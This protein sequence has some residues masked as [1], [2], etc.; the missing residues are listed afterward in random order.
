[1][2]LT[3]QK[4]ISENMEREVRRDEMGDFERQFSD[5][6][7]PD[8]LREGLKIEE[9]MEKAELTKKK[10]SEIPMS[11]HPFIMSAHAKGA[12]GVAARPWETDDNH[13]MFGNQ[14]GDGF[15]MVQRSGKSYSF[16]RLW[17]QEN[18]P[19][20]EPIKENGS[21]KDVVATLADHE[22][23]EK[24]TSKTEIMERTREKA[25]KRLA[26]PWEEEQDRIK[27]Y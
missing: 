20:V 22:I 10:W 24:P 5:P 17:V 13:M 7:K 21:L 3:K 8:Q 16:S 6:K 2:N 27:G 12:F 1:M 4:N 11:L 19:R 23:G 18:V 26:G 9:V 25:K 15:Y 14:A